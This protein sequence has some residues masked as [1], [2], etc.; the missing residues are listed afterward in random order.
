MKHKIKLKIFLVEI[1][2]N[3]YKNNKKLRKDQNNQYKLL[4][5]INLK[6]KKSLKN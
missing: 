1:V 6:N 3:T 5:I 4:L 2:K